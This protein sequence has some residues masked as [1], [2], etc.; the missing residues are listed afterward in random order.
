MYA[1]TLLTFT[2]LEGERHTFSAFKILG[3]KGND[4]ETTITYRLTDHSAPVAF[5][6][7]TPHAEV[8][9]L[10]QNGLALWETAAR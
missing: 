8:I 3:A 4:R 5:V 2:D 9:A 10:W 6:T 7:R 1:E